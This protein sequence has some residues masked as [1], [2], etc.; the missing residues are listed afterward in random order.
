M[1][2]PTPQKGQLIDHTYLS[3]IIEAVNTIAQTETQSQ[4]RGQ[5]TKSQNLQIVGQYKEITTNENVKQGDNKPFAVE[6]GIKF[7][8]IPIVTV[9]PQRA[10]RNVAS[11]EVS[12][13]IDSISESTVSGYITF[14]GTS[15]GAATIGINVIAVGI[16]TT[17]LG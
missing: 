2:I 7:K 9:T 8:N 17:S 15:T 16:P 1:R 6:F 5:T 10:T 13:V 12:V 3:Q 14:T 4:V 11:R